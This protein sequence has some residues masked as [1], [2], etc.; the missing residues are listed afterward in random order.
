VRVI[1]LDMIDFCKLGFGT[2]GFGGMA[3][4]N[5]ENDDVADI[6]TIRY[7]IE[8]GLT[9][10]DTAERYATGKTEEIVGRAIKPFKRESLFIASKVYPNHLGY[11]DVIKS[12]KASLKRLGVKYLDLYYIH[13]PNHDIPYAETGR[14]L[15]ELLDK[16]LIRR[17]GICNAT[18]DTIKKYQEYIRVPFFAMQNHYNL[19]VRES[20][21]KGVI[22]YCR[23]NNILF[24]AWRPI[25]LP[26]PGLGIESLAKVGAY[27]LLD[28][29]AKKYGK[30]N[31]QIAVRWLTQQDGVHTLFKSSNP[32]H[33]DE[34]LETGD[35]ELSEKDMTDLSK[36]FVPQKDCGFGTKG[37]MMPL[38]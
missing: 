33:I 8:K 36:N 3:E 24:F 22:D 18:I 19:I 10:I 26:A 17:V 34:V 12:C 25:Q 15:N 28:K 38:C 4:P 27:P 2:W 5:P 7:A 9:H 1:S 30:T 11:K 21:T 32:K 31:A 37:D 13:F 35:F 23:E 6:K 20:V 16:G 29:I 14:A